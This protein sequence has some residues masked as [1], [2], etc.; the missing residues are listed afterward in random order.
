MSTLSLEIWSHV[1]YDIP[2]DL[3]NDKAFISGSAE[4]AMSIFPFGGTWGTTALHY[5]E[6]I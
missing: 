5:Y 4:N 1:E 3:H 6:K 2:M